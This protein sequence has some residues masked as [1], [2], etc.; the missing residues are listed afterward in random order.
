LL[1]T[2]LDVFMPP[3]TA[4]EKQDRFRAKRRKLGMQ[5]ITVFIRPESTD[6]MRRIMRHHA[7]DKWTIQQVVEHA[8]QCLDNSYRQ[9]L[10]GTELEN[11]AKQLME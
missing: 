6:S 8:I 7:K 11:Y 4:S 1:V 9:R 2:I 3:L 10:A 5:R